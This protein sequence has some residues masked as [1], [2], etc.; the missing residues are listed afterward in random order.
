MEGDLQKRQSASG[1]TP[2]PE[3]SIRVLRRDKERPFAEGR[4]SSV[5]QTEVSL[6]GDLKRRKRSLVVKKYDPGPHFD[7]N[8]DEVDANSQNAFKKYQM[9]KEVGL[10]VPATYRLD[11][12]NNSIVMTDYNTGGRVALSHNAN[13]KFLG[14]KI[15]EIT[16]VTELINGLKRQCEIAAERKIEL[17]SDCF[18]LLCPARGGKVEADFVIADFDHVEQEYISTNK[19]DI[20]QLNVKR[21]RYFLLSTLKEH[22]EKGGLGDTVFSELWSE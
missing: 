21:A 8:D 19:E 11:R 2:K 17:P 15:T 6:T 14:R 5:Y 7:S 20:L 18:F 10:K 13:K 22:G 4:Y 1:G 16:N 3:K 12:K 9:C